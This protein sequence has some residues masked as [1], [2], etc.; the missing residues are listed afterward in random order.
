MKVALGALGVLA[1]FYFMTRDKVFG[2]RDPFTV[3]CV[4]W[5]FPR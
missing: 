2:L 4:L 1:T 5:T 3:I